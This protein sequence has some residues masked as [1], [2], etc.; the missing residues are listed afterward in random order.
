MTPSTKYISF[1]WFSALF[2]ITSQLDDEEGTS[3]A[4]ALASYNAK[5]HH[6]DNDFEE[7]TVAP[8]VDISQ[9]GTR[10]AVIASSSDSWK[11]G[12][13]PILLP[14][15]PATGNKFIWLEHDLETFDMGT[16]STTNFIA[17][18]GDKVQ[19][20]YWIS[21]TWSQFNNLQVIFIF[22]FGQYVSK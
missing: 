7:G 21:S 22:L 19:F 4:R 12:K 3:L 15:P 17:L 6:F 16:L 5:Q 8:W 11:T 20:S 14:P 9:G 13:V 10:W 18:P 2:A 1:L